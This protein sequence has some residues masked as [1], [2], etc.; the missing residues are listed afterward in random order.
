VLL[1]LY[2]LDVLWDSDRR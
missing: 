1:G 2:V